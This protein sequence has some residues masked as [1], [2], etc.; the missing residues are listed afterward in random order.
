MIRILFITV[1]VVLGVSS[2]NAQTSMSSDTLKRSTVSSNDS[3]NPI[4]EKK[5]AWYELIKFSGYAHIRYNRLLETNPNLKCDQCDKSIGEGGGFFIRR[6]R[7]K[8]S[9]QIHER[10][11]IYIQADVASNASS[12][13]SLGLNYLQIR[14]LYGDIFLTKT[15]THRIRPGISKVPFGFENLQS[16]QTRI[17]FDR[18]DAINS[19]IYNERDIG[20]FYYYTPVKIQERFKYIIYE[21]LKGSGNYGILGIG[22][23]N[24]QTANRQELNNNLHAVLRLTYPFLIGDKQII[25]VGVQ[26]YTG[27]FNVQEAKAPLTSVEKNYKGLNYV[28]QR[29]AA[30]F[31]LYPQPFGVQAE[32]VYGK[33]PT[34]QYNGPTAVNISEIVSGRNEGGYLQFMYMKRIKSMVFIPYLRGQY[35]YGGKKVELDARR[36]IVKDIEFGIEYQIIKQLELTVAYA[37]SDRVFE[38]SKNPINHQKGNFMRFQ[39]QFNY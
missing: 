12:G 29:V 10:F 38:D 7:L 11:Y 32:Y 16:S 25:E 30:S 33:S 5:K 14:D 36:Y 6:A 17:A 35:F 15:K 3:V 26:G 18:S 22:V 2:L 28:D 19:A 23:F 20:I 39:L 4:L 34:F 8:F 13:S 27:Q 37:I 1:V 31:I 21:G 9:G 24:G